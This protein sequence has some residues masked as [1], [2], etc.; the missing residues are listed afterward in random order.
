MKLKELLTPTL[1]YRTALGVS[2][3]LVIS[4]A[5]V[6][7]IQMKSLNQSVDLISDSNKKQFELEKI[8]TEIIQRESGIRSYIITKDSLFYENNLQLKRKLFNG[9]SQ[10]K[11]G[12]SSSEDIQN[13][14]N[15]SKDIQKRLALFEEVLAISN[16]KRTDPALLHAKLIEG[17]MQTKAIQQK[18]YKLIDKEVTKLKLHNINHRYDIETSTITAFS[19]TI[20]TLVVLLFSLNKINLDFVKVRKLNEELKFVNQVS[21]NAEKVAGISH[22]KINIK[23]GKF[24]Y[25]DNFFRILGLKPHAFEQNLDNF[26]PF[27]HPDDVE[28]AVRQHEESMRNHTPTSMIYRIVRQDGEIRY[29]NSTGDFTHN[30]KGELVKIGVSNDITEEYTNKLAL[31]EKNRTLIAM[32]AELESFNQIVSHD[33]Q[34]P[35]RK[36]QMFISRIEDSDFETISE[37]GRDYFSKIKN[38]AN[39]MQNL[40]MDLVDY[41]KTIKDDKVFVKTNLNKLLEDVVHELALNIEEKNAVIEIGNLPK[42]NTIPFQIHQLFVNLISNSLKYSKETTPPIIKIKAVKIKNGEKIND[43]ELSDKK[44]YKITVTDN[45]IGFKQEFSEK[46]FMLFKRLETDID[47]SG[48]GIGLAICKKI[49]ENHNGFIKAEGKPDIGSVFILYLPK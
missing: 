33:L 36:I 23:T 8:I 21:D 25:S 20:I 9:L 15:L 18:I 39:R 41:S 38:A 7:H 31:E 19:L 40:M 4:V 26:T 6:F 1:V 17:N 5:I 46:I 10:L 2:F 42:L 3:I 14:E 24:F 16:S 27:I 22:W 32:N 28:D 35:L 44:Y 30:S 34:E 13:I 45:G 11:S 37:K 48:T 29:I 12:Y 47:Y 49:I 43:I